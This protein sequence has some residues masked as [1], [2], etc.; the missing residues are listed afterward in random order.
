MKLSDFQTNG[1]SQRVKARPATPDED[2]DG[3]ESEDAMSTAEAQEVLIGS[4]RCSMS[5]PI[6][7]LSQ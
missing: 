4:S 3:D 7:L 1:V 5:L 6:P 2:G